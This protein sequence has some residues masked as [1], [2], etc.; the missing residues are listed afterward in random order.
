MK[1]ILMVLAATVVCGASLFTSCKKDEEK[2]DNPATGEVRLTQQYMVAVR[3]TGDTLIITNEDF[4]WENG[5]LRSSHIL[6]GFNGSSSE[7]VTNYLYDSDGNCIAEHETSPNLS[8]DRYYT[9][10]GGRMTRA[11][12][13]TDSD[14]TVRVTIT[15]HTADGHIQTLT[16]ESLTSGRVT[17]QCGSCA[18][19][20]GEPDGVDAPPA[21]DDPSVPERRFKFAGYGGQGILSLGICVAEAARLEKRHTLWFPSYGPEQRGGSASCSVVVSGTP[22]GSPTVEHPD[23]LVCMNQPSYE[24]FVGDVKKGGTVIVDASVPIAK[25]PPE[26]VTLCQ[27]PALKMAEDFGVPKAANTMMLAAL[28]AFKCTGL[29][30]T[31]LE[32]ALCASFKKKPQL[33]EKN[34]DLLKRAEAALTENQH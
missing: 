27:V 5:L 32:T 13:M 15:G 24:R 17:A 1:R 12:E 28:S 2:P 34:R 22:I 19:L 29:E 33:V 20:F 7:F 26:G 6:M 30:R 25:Q 18:E 23:V 11:I 4:V 3:T 9:Y 10:E 31:H 8:H 16:V 14:T 21:E